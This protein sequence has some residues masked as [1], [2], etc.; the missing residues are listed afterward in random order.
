LR[1]DVKSYARFLRA[2]LLSLFG[3]LEA[4]VNEICD[5]IQKPALKDRSLCKRIDILIQ[6]ARRIA[7]VPPIVLAPGKPLRDMIAHPGI[8]KTFDQVPEDYGAT[9]ERLDFQALEQFEAQISPWIDGICSA[10]RVNRL[11]DA[12][13]ALKEFTEHLGKLTGGQWSKAMPAG[14]PTS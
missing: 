10:F 8:E 4:V 12:E 9:Y 13:G 1:D 6:D 14:G 7:H 11:E 2:A 3:H 5:I